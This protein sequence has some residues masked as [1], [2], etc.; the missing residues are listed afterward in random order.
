MATIE[1]KGMNLE[2][3]FD[4]FY[5]IPDYQREYVWTQKEVN[6]FIQDI[7]EEFSEQT[8]NS[9]PEYFIGSIIVCGRGEKF[10]EIIDGQQRITTA[11]LVLC[12]IRDYLLTINPNE[13]IEALKNKIAALYTDN[14]GN[15][16]FRHKVELQYQESRGI[17]ENIAL[18]ASVETLSPTRSVKNIQ[19][20]YTEI[21]SFLYQY[22][23]VDELVV[24]NIKKFYAYFLKNVKL[25]RVKTASVSHA[26][27]IYSTLNHRGLALDDMDLLKNL[28]FT[29]AKSTDYDQIKVKWKTMIDLLYNHQEKPMRFLRY[30]ILAKYAKDGNYILEKEVYDWFLNNEHICRYKTEPIQF[31][32]NLLSSAQAYVAFLIGNNVDGTVNRYLVNIRN[33][34]IN[35]RQHLILLLAV[36]KLP[37][38][39]F[40]DLCRQIE[41]LLFLAM[42]TS[43][44]HKKAFD[45][46]IIKW[47]S[48]L[49]TISSQEDYDIFIAQEII[50]SKQGVADKFENT[51]YRLNKLSLQLYQIR[52]ILAKITQYI[53]EMAWGTVGGI[54][55]LRNYVFK[56]EVE[57]I[58]SENPTKEVVFDFDKPTEIVNYS[59]RLGNMTLLE[60]SIKSAILNASF[61]EK[62]LGYTKSRF[63]LTRT[64][65]E[66]ISVGNNTTI[67]LAVKDLKTFEK[68][69][70]QAI[71]TRQEILT[72][73]AKKVWDVPE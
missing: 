41:N 15:D 62:K 2:K 7:Y 63:L 42:L 9:Y 46:M 71:E 19:N 13:P 18:Q 34:S 52:Y 60:S 17:L 12:A 47:A 11:Y 20:A 25:I 73:L 27:K 5:V 35:V 64:I 3:L 53:D 50:P 21:R 51:F 44:R 43:D 40:V 37:K 45:G 39:C 36:D 69:D 10:Y 70:S 67:N 28:I 1:S 48:E 72:Q 59:Q 57:Q 6:E 23:Q 14:W 26:L 32:N 66:E 65:A 68:W 61:T 56:L 22:F 30:F 33:L 4:E 49:R 31:V 55:D 8:Q 38:A 24:F 16:Q 29:K 54:D 58:L